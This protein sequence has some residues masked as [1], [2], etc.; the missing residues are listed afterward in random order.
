MSVAMTIPAWLQK[1]GMDISFPHAPTW[2]NHY[3]QQQRD[4]FIENGLPTRKNERWKYTDLS[5]LTNTNF[6]IAM[7]VD[8]DRLLDAVHQHRLQHGASILLVFVNGY[9][10]PMLSDM[11]MLPQNVIACSMG[12]ALQNHTEKVQANWMHTI[13]AQHYPFGSLNAAMFVDGLFFYVP[14][15][16]ELTM[17]IHFL[18]LAS[19]DNEFIAHPHHMIILGRNSK[20]MLVEEY[21][22]WLEH[23]YMMNI[24]TTMVVLEN[25]TLNHCKIQHEGKQAVHMAHTF[26]Y[27]K[28]N[29]SVT[30]TNFSS[31]SLFARDEVVVKLQEFGANCLTCGF[32]HLRYDNQY[33]DHHIDI[34]HAAP[35]SNSEM[36]YKGI[37]DKKSRAVFNG[38]LHVEKDAQKILAYQANHNLLLSKDAEVYSKPE[39]EIYADDVKCKHGATTGQIDREALFYM[40][41]RGIDRD[42]AM[43]ILLQGFAEEVIKR[44]THLGVKMRVQEMMCRA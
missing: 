24:V 33:I 12:D 27:Q 28:Q 21:F 8:A 7:R 17:P 18:S 35:H 26:I 30:F 23:A 6:S 22:S 39:L 42:D 14:D 4:A 43:N 16:I 10:M 25:A 1:S 15:N 29:S 5:F 37:I 19:G 44:I 34:D 9:F 3:R 40:R 13:D 11:A 20:M 32:Y 36:L 38:R 41:S 2:L 31:G